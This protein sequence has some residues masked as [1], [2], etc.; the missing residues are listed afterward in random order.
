MGLIEKSS[1]Y[2]LFGSISARV[3]ELL[4]RYSAWQEVYSIDECFLGV[5]RAGEDLVAL[6]R[7]MKD[8]CQQNIGVSVCVGIAPL[9]VLP[10]IREWTLHLLSDG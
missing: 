3:M 7:A 10:R 4:A 9:Q 5:K 8:A 1:N 2:E 6:G